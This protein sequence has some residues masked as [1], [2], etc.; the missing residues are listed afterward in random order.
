MIDIV[1]PWYA[2][3]FAT[4]LDYVR[5]A[6]GRV[7]VLRFADLLH[8]APAAVEAILEHSG[9]PKPYELCEIAVDTAQ[10]ERGTLRFN[11]GEQGRGSRLPLKR[12]AGAHRA[13][14]V[15]MLRLGRVARRHHA[16]RVT[17]TLP[18]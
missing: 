2:S 6:P 4:W 10:R 15:R 7:R 18:P 12:T 9:L 1:A 17:V 14:A 13:L 16:G 3:Y 11:K 5:E 8:D